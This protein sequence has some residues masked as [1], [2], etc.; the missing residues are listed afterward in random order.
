[1]ESLAD[2]GNPIVLGGSFG[3]LST[4][5]FFAVVGAQADF[6]RA[7][8]LGLILLG[9]A[10][11]PSSLQRGVVG[12]KLLRH[13]CRA[14]AMPACRNPCPPRSRRAA[15][16]V[17]VP[18]AVLT[19]GVY[20]LALA[21]G[22]VKVWGRDWTPTLSH[23][24]RAFAVE[25]GPAGVIWAGSAWNSLFTTIKLAAIGAPITAAIGLLAA[26]VF[27]RQRFVGRSD[28]EF[29]LMLRSACP[30]PSSASPTS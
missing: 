29:A 17:A 24:G 14:R 18:W 21:G 25:R 13:R 30:E 3:V 9:F 16:A 2:F 1:M 23:F 20:L 15:I 28:L 5:I 22:F 10:L 12:R 7:A 4:E 11:P 8:T 27:S 26:W 6:G 19:I